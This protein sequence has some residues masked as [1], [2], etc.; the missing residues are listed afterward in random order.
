MNDKDIL[1]AAWQHLERA[2]VHHEGRPVGTIA[3]LDPGPEP[4]NYDQ[5]FTRDFFISGLAFLL[6]DKFEI[7]RNFLSV[8]AD[9]Q[10][11]NKSTDCFR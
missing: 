2:I 6:N 4:L 10:A 8:T 1:A 5:I 3:S 7:V 11:T 9:L